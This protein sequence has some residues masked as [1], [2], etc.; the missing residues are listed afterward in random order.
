MHNGFP[1]VFP[2]AVDEGGLQAVLGPLAVRLGLV[3]FLCPATRGFYVL[4][5]GYYS[6]CV[7]G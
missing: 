1:Y 3:S 4:L 7:C 2:F 6:V 5:L